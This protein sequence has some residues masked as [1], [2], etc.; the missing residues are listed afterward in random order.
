MTFLKENE[1]FPTISA[2]NAADVA[3]VADASVREDVN[4]S[5]EQMEAGC[6][7]KRKLLETQVDKKVSFLS[8]EFSLL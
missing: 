3:D 5:G 7:A 8:L 6:N 2:T 4:G 1:V